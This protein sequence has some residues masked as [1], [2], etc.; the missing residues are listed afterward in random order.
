MSGFYLEGVPPQVASSSAWIGRENQVE[1]LPMLDPGANTELDP[2]KPHK[3]LQE[4]QAVMGGLR[5]L[6][7]SGNLRVAIV[8]FDRRDAQSLGPDFEEGLAKSD[9]LAIQHPGWTD[10]TLNAELLQGAAGALPEPAMNRMLSAAAANRQI[11]IAADWKDNGEQPEIIL[12]KLHDARIQAYDSADDGRGE[13]YMRFQH[14]NLLYTGLREW[15]ALGRL[16]YQLGMRQ[17]ADRV[18]SGADNRKSDAP[19]NTKEPFVVTLAV[20][21]IHA[22]IGRKLDILGVP[23]STIDRTKEH[24]LDLFSAQVPEMIRQGRI[25]ATRIAQKDDGVYQR[26][27]HHYAKRLDA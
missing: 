6:A 19:L 8:H 25:M 9:Y 20:D 16:G 14:L 7:Y 12:K 18:L 23:N 22:D 15:T 24:S 5:A 13:G 10:Q 27:T 1:Q 21:P 26:Y 11:P 4:G 3:L 2:D 17:G